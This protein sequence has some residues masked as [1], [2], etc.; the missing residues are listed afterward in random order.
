MQPETWRAVVGFEGLYEVSTTG[1]VRSLERVVRRRC[2]RVPFKTVRGTILK[3]CIKKGGYPEVALS[4][5][6]RP[7]RMMIHRLVALAFIPNPEPAV[8]TCVDHIN[9]NTAD[10]R[11]ENLRWVTQKQNIN[12]ARDR[13]AFDNRTY[14][15]GSRAPNAKLTEEAVI[16]I[17]NSCVKYGD[18]RKIAERFGVDQ[19]LISRILKR[20]AWAHI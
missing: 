11:I 13:G 1:S 7:K 14:P 17:R 8:L 6:G 3:P 16:L 4:K 18:K 19:S 9:G 10:A 5:D 2:K 15:N 12:Y 20:K